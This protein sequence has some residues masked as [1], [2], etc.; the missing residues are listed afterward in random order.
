MYYE[1]EFSLDGKNAEV[2]IEV[3]SFDEAESF[4]RL[5]YPTAVIYTIS[6]TENSPFVSVA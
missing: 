2:Y 5:I 3:S 4:F 1:I 6:E